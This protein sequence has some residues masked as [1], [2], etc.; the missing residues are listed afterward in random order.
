VEGAAAVGVGALLNQKINVKGK[1]V[2]TLLSGSTINS[3]EYLRIIQARLSR[4]GKP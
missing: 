3:E 1:H 2:V 4:G